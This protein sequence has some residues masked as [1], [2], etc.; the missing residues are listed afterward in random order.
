MSYSFA[1]YNLKI[2]SSL[3]KN[4]QCPPSKKW[5]IKAIKLVQKLHILA[6]MKAEGAW[7]EVANFSQEAEERS[8]RAKE[9]LPGRGQARQ[10]RT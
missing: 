9:G 7:P 8:S 5:K 10:K 4:T 2:S 1:S 6:P 3:W